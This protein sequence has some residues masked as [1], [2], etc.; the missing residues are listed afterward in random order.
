MFGLYGMKDLATMTDLEYHHPV[1]PGRSCVQLVD[2]GCH[3]VGC[4]PYK[5]LA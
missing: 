3:R 4:P 1:D 5:D 2:L